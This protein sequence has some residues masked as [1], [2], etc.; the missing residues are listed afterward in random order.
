MLEVKNLMV[1]FENALALND[2]SIEV[3][4]G[5]IVSALGSNSAGKTTLMNTISGLIIDMKV[6]EER[7]GA[8]GSLWWAKYGSREKRSFLPNR[9]LES[10]EGLL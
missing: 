4:R 2:L 3:N 8:N 1:F 6:K 9:V 5:E 10:G 7:R